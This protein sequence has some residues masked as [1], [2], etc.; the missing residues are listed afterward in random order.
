MLAIYGYEKRQ[1]D[2]LKNT[3]LVCYM[4]YCTNAKDPV[5]IDKF[6]QIGNEYDS[7]ED[8]DGLTQDQIQQLILARKKKY[9]Q[10][11]A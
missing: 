11:S 10:P 8:E 2:K 5:S 1:L 9:D 7:E 6:M 4:V 3:R